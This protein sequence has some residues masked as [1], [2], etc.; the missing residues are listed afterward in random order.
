MNLI[1]KFIEVSM[2]KI[3]LWINVYA[4]DVTAEKAIIASNVF[5]LPIPGT[6]TQV[7]LKLS[8]VNPGFTRRGL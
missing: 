5:G 6:D 8:M 3:A 4:D 2:N 1:V 7:K